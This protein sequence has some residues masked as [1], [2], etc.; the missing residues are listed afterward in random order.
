MIMVRGMSILSIAALTGM[1][2]ST[3]VTEGRGLNS[4]HPG[5]A[6]GGHQMEA[7]P[8]V[9]QDQLAGKWKQFKGDH[10]L[11]VWADPADHESDSP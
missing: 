11:K 10:P 4:L 1:G 5:P 3:G 8:V 7:T 2:L 9:N 6:G